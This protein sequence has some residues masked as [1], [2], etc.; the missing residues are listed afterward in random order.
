[1][2][3]SSTITDMTLDGGIPCLDLVNSG[4]GTYKDELIE[5]LHHYT[6]LLTLAERSALLGPD[7][8][9][10]LKR[11]AKRR[12]DEAALVLNSTR[13]VRLVMH[14]IF[15]PIAEGKTHSIDK[16][17]LKEFNNF[18]IQ[19]NS[20]QSFKIVEEKLALSMHHSAHDLRRPLDAFI[21]SAY[22]LLHY[23]DQRYIKRCS[24]CQWLFID[25]SKSHRRKWCNMQDCGSIVKSSRY[26]RKKRAL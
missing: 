1:M 13:Q 24:R 11:E 6:D 16:S 23:K 14:K 3:V 25:E 8:I 2:A 4:L 18:I 7:V 9:A 15:S 10:K 22:A 26:Y 17:T 19:A 5:R 21:I 12:P 20:T